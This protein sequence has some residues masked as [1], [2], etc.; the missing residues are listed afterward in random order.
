[1]ARKAAVAVAAPAPAPAP[2]ARTIVFVLGAPGAGKGTQCAK[3]AAAFGYTHLSTGDLLRD[4]VA[5]GSELGERLKGIMAAGALVETP[6][7][8]QMVEKAMAASGSSKF[9]LDGYPRALD[10]A[11]AFEKAIGAPAFVLA[12]DADEATLEARLVQRGLTSGRADDNV[13]SIRK[14]FATFKAQSEAVID[15]YGRVGALR[16]VDSLRAPDA[17]FADVA[18]HFRPQCVW[19]LGGP[20]AGRSTVA[21]RAV[22]EGLGWHHLS[23][24]ALMRA[25]VARGT[26]LGHELDAVM[27]RG[28]SAPA[29]V[30]VRLLR[31]AI[32]AAGP[33]GRFILDGAPA[34]LEQA[35]A[36]DRE[37]GPPLCI[38]NLVAPDAVLLARVAAGRGDASRHDEHTA[39]ARKA[40]AGYHEATEP[41]VALYA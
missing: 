18:P 38:I 34:D 25:E 14:R 36:F 15:F 4:E 30:A 1:V 19:L 40:L 35:V 11:F 9:L 8:L 27:R 3:I 7:V 17:V 41:V 31:E 26:E 16:R 37:F 13:E 6:L 33:A 5:S 12:F 28:D 23:T 29:E 32:E 10:Q 22:A 39:V 24:G 20:G 21:A 2:T